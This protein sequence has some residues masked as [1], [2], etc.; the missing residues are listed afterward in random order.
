MADYDEKENKF[1][2]DPDMKTNSTKKTLTNEE[3]MAQAI[4]FLLAGYETTAT[5]LGYI[6]YNL[7]LYPDC[8]KKL[9]EEI[10]D[11]IEK[12]VSILNHSRI[13]FIHF[14]ESSNARLFIIFKDFLFNSKG[15]I[16]YAMINDVPFLDMII[17]ESLRLFPPALRT[18]RL[19]CED[20]E[21]EGMKIPKGTIINVSVWALHHDSE[22]YPEPD[23]F[24]PE[25]FGT[26]ALFIILN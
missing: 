13:Y 3:I 1:A 16:N 19:T 9:I 25:R 24:I 23:K 22:I 8:Q 18:D 14:C 26:R 20:Y 6:A 4:L 10:D 12:H 2:D 17:D 7:A 15:E 21:Y 11:G 5:A